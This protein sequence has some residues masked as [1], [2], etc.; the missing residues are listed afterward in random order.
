MKKLLTLLFFSV[1]IT[2]N[3]Q[4]AEI[5]N[6]QQ[7]KLVINQF[8]E[9]LENQDSLLLTNVKMP[10]SQIWRIYSSENPT[11]ANMRFIEDDIETLKDLPPLKE[12]ALDFD[13]NIHENIAVAWVPYEFWLKN[14]FSHCG[15]DIFNLFNIDGEWKI[16]SA[17]YSVQKD[18]CN[19][20]RGAH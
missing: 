3:S 14:K 9:A 20:L 11:K 16:V 1:A 18:N 8:F 15:I 12:I 17:A 19:D 13:I 10:K 7:I 5:D 2:A 6:E 4:D